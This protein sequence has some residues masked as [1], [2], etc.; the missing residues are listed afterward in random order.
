MVSIWKSGKGEK[1]KKRG[2]GGLASEVLTF[3]LNAVYPSFSVPLN[4]SS[5]YVCMRM[6]THTHTIPIINK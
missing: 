6:H 1:E 3:A 2:T 5:P 4:C